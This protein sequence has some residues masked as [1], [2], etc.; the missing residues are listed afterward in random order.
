MGKQGHNTVL[1]LFESDLDAFE[2]PEDRE[3]YVL[4]T[5]DQKHYL[6]KHPDI[7]HGVHASYL[8]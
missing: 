6:F 5:L 1:E 8:H 2:T 3:R 7:G 4:D